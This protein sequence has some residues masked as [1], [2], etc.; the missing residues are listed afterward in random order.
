M[1]GMGIVRAYPLIS[2]MIQD[3]AHL[4]DTTQAAWC[5]IKTSILSWNMPGDYSALSVK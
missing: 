1:A 5:H 4:G 2:M 3:P